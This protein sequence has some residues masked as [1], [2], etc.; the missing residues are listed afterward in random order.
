MYQDGHRRAKNQSNWSNASTVQVQ[1]VRGPNILCAPWLSGGGGP[2]APC[3]Y[4]PVTH[5][6]APVRFVVFTV[7][8]ID[9][10]TVRPSRFDGDLALRRFGLTDRFVK[11][12]KAVKMRWQLQIAAAEWQRRLLACR[13]APLLDLELHRLLSSGTDGL[14]TAKCC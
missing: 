10:G 14:V 3:S 7:Y 6:L 11:N 4:A 9:F 1:K 8:L 12:A 5:V 2:P 13:H